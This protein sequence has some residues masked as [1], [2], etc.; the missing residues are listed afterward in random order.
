[1]NWLSVLLKEG[2]ESR[3]GGDQ[4]VIYSIINSP[5]CKPEEKENHRLQ[6]TYREGG[7]R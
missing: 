2:C 6:G 4:R 7:N 5:F 1:M 3:Y